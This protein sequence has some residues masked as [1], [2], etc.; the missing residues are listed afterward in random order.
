MI[1]GAPALAGP[2][3]SGP[4]TGTFITGTS[5]AVSSPT[6]SALTR[7][8]LA[9]RTLT[10]STF[11]GA[12]LVSAAAVFAHQSSCPGRVYAGDGWSCRPR[13]LCAGGAV[14][15]A[16]RPANGAG[17]GSALAGAYPRGPL[18]PGFELYDLAGECPS[19]LRLDLSLTLA[20]PLQRGIGC[21]SGAFASWHMLLLARNGGAWRACNPRARFTARRVFARLPVGHYLDPALSLG[22]SI[23]AG[24]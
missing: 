7:S 11:A 3:T 1:G 22:W 20:G 6:G 2:L 17:E 15:V 24:G 23:R 13:C 16:G 18:S 21:W 19:A 9:C 5:I 10:G 14:G 12:L 4:P 8:P